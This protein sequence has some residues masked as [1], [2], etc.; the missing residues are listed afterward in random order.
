MNVEGTGFDWETRPNELATSTT[1]A[2]ESL[3]V[4]LGLLLSFLSWYRPPPIDLHKYLLTGLS[5]KFDVVPKEPKPETPAT[6]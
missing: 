2:N 4:F 6:T 1:N 3:K 5:L